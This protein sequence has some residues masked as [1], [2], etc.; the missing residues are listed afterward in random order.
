MLITRT[1]TPLFKDLVTSAA[2][3]HDVAAFYDLPTLGLRDVLLPRLLENPDKTLPQWF[4]TS[5]ELQAG[6][7]DAKVRLWGGQ[8]VDLMHVSGYRGRTSCTK[9]ERS[10][11]RDMRCSLNLSFFTSNVNWLLWRLAEV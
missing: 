11:P 4:R 6:E 3:H 10:R 5:P 2:L 9:R 7:A 1:F 8:A